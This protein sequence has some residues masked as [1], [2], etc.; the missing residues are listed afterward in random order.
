MFDFA[1]TSAPASR[2]LRTW[3]ASSGGLNPA[4]A[5][6]FTLDVNDVGRFLERVGHPNTVRGGSAL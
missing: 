3:N 5:I 4:S 6:D 2:S 1:K